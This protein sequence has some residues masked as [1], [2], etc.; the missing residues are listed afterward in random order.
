MTVSGSLGAAVA[1]GQSETESTVR[2][3]AKKVMAVLAVGMLSFG[4]AAPSFATTRDGTMTKWT[5]GD[6]SADWSDSNTTSTV[7][8]VRFYATCSHDF[9]ARIRKN[10]VG[11]DTTMASERI[12]CTSYNDSVVGGD[13]PAD[14]YHFD[15][16]ESYVAGCCVYYPYLSGNYRITW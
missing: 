9:D 11:P 16:H 4:V 14:S 12:N 1:R 6:Q 7:T 13:Y 8:S 10:N 3:Q 15:V 5:D 2:V